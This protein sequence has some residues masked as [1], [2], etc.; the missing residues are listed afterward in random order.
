MNARILNFLHALELL[1]TSFLKSNALNRISSADLQC[2]YRL[3]ASQNDLSAFLAALNQAM[4]PLKTLSTVTPEFSGIFNEASAIL[5]WA[6]V[7]SVSEKPLMARLCALNRFLDNEANDYASIDISRSGDLRY[8]LGLS[9]HDG[10]LAHF[11]ASSPAVCGMDHDRFYDHFFGDANTPLREAVEEG[12][13]SLADFFEQRFILR[14][15]PI[16]SRKQLQLPEDI[17][18]GLKRLSL[19]PAAQALQLQQVTG[20]RF[21]TAKNDALRMGM[22]S[23]RGFALLY[24]SACIRTEVDIKPLIGRSDTDKCLTLADAFLSK[25]HGHLASHWQNRLETIVEGEG[26]IDG[27]HYDETVFLGPDAQ[28]QAWQN[29]SFEPELPE[30]HKPLH[31]PTPVIL[32]QNNVLTLGDR[33]IEPLSPMTKAQQDLFITAIQS[34]PVNSLSHTRAVQM[35]DGWTILCRNTPLFLSEKFNE[36]ACSKLF[37]QQERALEMWVGRLAAQVRGDILIHDVSDKSL[38]LGSVDGQPYRR[39]WFKTTLARLL[40]DPQT[41]PL[42]AIVRAHNHAVEIYDNF[43]K[44]AFR[45]EDDDFRAIRQQPLR[46]LNDYIDAPLV[47][48]QVLTHLW[49]ADLFDQPA[50]IP[51]PPIARQTQAQISVTE[52]DTHYRVPLGTP[53]YPIACGR[54]VKC[55]TIP[56]LGNTILI[57]HACGLCSRYAHLATLGGVPGQLVSADTMI[58]RSGADLDG[59]VLTICKPNH[60][61]QS[62]NDFGDQTLSS[63]EVLHKIWTNMPVPEML[64]L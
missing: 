28:N 32:S 18:G 27:R 55:G 5:D 52:T 35:P 53:I 60:K 64:I 6:G 24:D 10:S 34:L 38:P 9:L 37:P 17:E 11:L 21:N 43:D 56:K 23:L 36:V 46:R 42:K 49:L 47:Q 3:L 2:V 15:D 7:N 51:V 54:I 59:L 1:L 63:S 58:A 25:M 39:R 22:T 13:N 48:M 31:E 4:T 40:R 19:H 33:I 44:H 20:K 14:Y 57:E 45:L 16:L 41:L 8:G 29:A 61:V 30:I 62:W 26:D 12:Q 50:E